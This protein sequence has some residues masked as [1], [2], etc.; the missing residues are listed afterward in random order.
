LPQNSHEAHYLSTW[1]ENGAKWAGKTF[2][3]EMWITPTH[4]FKIYEGF[5]EKTQ[6]MMQFIYACQ[7]S[8]I[9]HY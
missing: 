5:E 2:L 4:V 3:W 6:S 1:N 7:G 8:Q 9:L